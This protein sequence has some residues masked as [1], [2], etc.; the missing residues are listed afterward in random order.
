MLLQATYFEASVRHLDFWSSTSAASLAC[1]CLIKGQKVD[2]TSVYGDLVKRTYWVCVL[3]ER[4]FNLEFRVAS[5]GIE[6]L[7][8]QVPL[9]HFHVTK[10]RISDLLSNITDASTAD[11]K[12]GSAFYFVAILALSRLI[13]RTDNI[14]DVYEPSLTET[15]LL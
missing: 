11:G 15:D 2:W 5:T 8:D 1:I 14:L 13:R 6:S 4:L 3:Q 10:E 9:P 12:R 7:E